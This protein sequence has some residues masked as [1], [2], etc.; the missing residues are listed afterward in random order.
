MRP[1]QFTR[2]ENA[3]AAV[4]AHPTD[5]GESSAASAPSQYLAGGTTLID[6]MK[7]D[8]MRPSRVIEISAL[9][10]THG[11]IELDSTG[12]HLGAMA[13]MADVADHD[14]VRHHFPMIA[15]ALQLAASA[16]IRNMA[17]GGTCSSA[18]GARTSGTRP[19]RIVTNASPA[20]AAP[21]CRVSTDHTPCSE[22]AIAASPATPVTSHRP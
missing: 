22:R 14:G 21:P 8:V 11:R 10:K 15:Q 1:F 7:L 3:K 6:L 9:H 18:P 2:A 17:S 5:P 4:L 20:P 19:T 16:Q 12:L 13:R